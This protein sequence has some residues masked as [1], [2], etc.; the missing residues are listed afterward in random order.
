[1]HERFADWL[2]R[3]AGD[4]VA[5]QEE[6]VAYHLEQAHAYRTQLGPPD[7][8]SDAIGRRASMRHASAGRRASERSDH[9]AAANLLRRAAAIGAVRGSERARLLYDLG[10]ALGWVGEAQPGAGRSTR[11]SG[12]PPRPATGPEWLA[13]IR[14]SSAQTLTDPHGK[15]TDEFRAELES[16]ARG[17]SGWATM[18]SL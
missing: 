16:A 14:R 15:P 6:I 9:A 12:S 18:P 8:R 3:V 7:E 5:E 11:R 4:A 13:R 10:D 17:A 1:M 2:E